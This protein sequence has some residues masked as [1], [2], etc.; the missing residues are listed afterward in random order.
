MSNR[1]SVATF[2]LDAFAVDRTGSVEAM[3]NACLDA[4]Q[5]QFDAVAPSRPD[6]IVLPES[7]TLFDGWDTF[8]ASRI[9]DYIDCIGDRL[10]DRCKATAAAQRA[11]VVAC[12]IRRLADGRRYN[13]STVIGPDGRELGVYCKNNLV[14]EEHTVYGC[15]YGTQADLIRTPFGTIACAICFDLNFEPLRSHYAALR[16]DLLV[17]S[18]I[19]HGGLLQTLW[20]FQCRCHMVG[21]MAISRVPGEI[22]DPFGRVLHSTTNYT[23]Q[24]VGEVNLDC[25]VAHLDYNWEKFA[26][27]KRAYGRG[28]AIDDPGRLGSVLITSETEGKSARELAAEFGIEL[29]DDYLARAQGVRKDVI[30]RQ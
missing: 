28:V 24:V 9:G 10:I 12:Q 6:L 19:F 29:L 11:T 8:E 1:I 5:R 13:C 25:V 22:R 4:W 23:G 20:P 26:Q 16:P 3:A 14:I 18:S 21:S 2:S 27:L 17:F 15:D 7:S 30:A